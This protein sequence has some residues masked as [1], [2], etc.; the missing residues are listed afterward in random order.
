MNCFVKERRCPRCER[1]ALKTWQELTPDEK[2][3]AEKLPASAS[4]T[5]EER[6]K[7]RFCTYCWNEEMEEQELPT[8]FNA[9]RI[10][11]FAE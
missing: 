2:M 1:L 9:A 6:R 3:L 5:A 10:G 8:S 11:E 4:F 7:H